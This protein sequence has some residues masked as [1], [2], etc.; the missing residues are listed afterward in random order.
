MKG[1]KIIL[2]VIFSCVVAGA[3]GQGDIEDLLIQEVDVVN[4]VYKPV[5]GVGGGLFN[6]FGEIRDPGFSPMIGTPGF[7]INVSTF[8]DNKHYFRG[9][10]YLI[11][12]KVSG[13]ERSFTDISRNFNFQSNIYAFGININYDFDNF[14]K[15]D[16]TCHPFIALG[17]ETVTFNSK[18][19]S[20]GANGEKYNYWTDG[21]IRNLPESPANEGTSQIMQRDY[22]YE[23]NLR[24]YDWGMGAYPQY[25][26]A[27]PI[28]VG[29][30]FW[31]SYRV[32]L[33]LSTSYHYTF[34]DLID[35]VSHKN[36]SG[37]IG[38]KMNDSFLYTSVSLNFD[39]FSDSKTLTVEKLFADVDFDYTL[40][41]DEDNDGTFD[42]WDQC[43]GTPAGVK[44]DSVGCP[45]DDDLDGVPN[46]KD[47]QPNTPYGA[48]VN[49][50]GVEISDD[51]LISSLDNSMAVKRDE[52]EL[53]LRTPSSY[54]TYQ[55]G[56]AKEIP[57]KFKKLD[58]NNDGYIS[59]DEMLDA[60]DN[61]FDFNSTLTTQDIYDLNN[62]FFSQ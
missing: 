5:V 36:T 10:F 29:L 12:G 54:T 45:L 7:N 26:F 24:N 4:P 34:T 18:I 37:I 60:I 21:T 13:N 41:G 31:I 47:D 11:G 59:F 50:R 3:Y 49:D 55:G 39:L 52:V 61:F 28:E 38:D 16:R 42:G 32:M 27:V 25:T 9:D 1:A 6:Y 15:Q 20:L 53:Y 2:F 62:F 43:P 35:H 40:Y 33:R 23:T 58:T 56:A 14:F 17:I 57:A 51:Q 8:I 44:V 19:D 30:D 48:F 22:V 46:Y